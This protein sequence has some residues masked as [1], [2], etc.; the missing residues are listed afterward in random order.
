MLFLKDKNKL[1]N[2]KLDKCQVVEG[3]V[4]DYTVLKIAIESQDIVYV[5]LS[6]DLGRMGEIIVKA[7]KETGV[8]RVIAFNS[9]GI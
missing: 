6:G 2:I 8:K 5:N 3:D 7:M 9:I 4:L 1:A